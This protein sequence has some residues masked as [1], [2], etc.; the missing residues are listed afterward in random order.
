[1][2]WIYYFYITQISTCL[3]NHLIHMVLL[4]FCPG[5]IPATDP[6][7]DYCSIMDNVQATHIL[8]TECDC[9]LRHWYWW[10]I[11]H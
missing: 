10:R 4:T 2:S 6:T 7:V 3:I 11:N 1:M 8:S 9:W 5:L